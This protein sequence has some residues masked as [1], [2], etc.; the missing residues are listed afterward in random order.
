MQVVDAVASLNPFRQTAE[1]RRR[2]TQQLVRENMAWVRR[3]QQLEQIF[4]FVRRE[5]C[6][7]NRRFGENLPAAVVPAVQAELCR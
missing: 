5:A 6:V 4:D 7:K 1:E 2:K 3:I